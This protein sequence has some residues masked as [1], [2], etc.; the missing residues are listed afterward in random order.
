MNLITVEEVRS[1]LIHQMEKG[2]QKASVP[3]NFELADI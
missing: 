3:A 1:A 2:K